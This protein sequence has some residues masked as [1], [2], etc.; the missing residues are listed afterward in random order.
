MQSSTTHKVKCLLVDAGN[1]ALAAERVIKS[2]VERASD[3]LQQA[4]DRDRIAAK[5][6]AL[7]IRHRW[8]ASDRRNLETLGIKANPKGRGVAL[9]KKYE[10]PTTKILNKAFAI[11]RLYA[12]ETL[13]GERLRILRQ[14]TPWFNV[15][16]EALYR[17]EHRI[18]C[19]LGESAPS[20]KAYGRAADCLMMTADLLR[21]ICQLVRNDRRALGAPAEPVLYV[22]DFEIWK[23]TG[24]FPKHQGDN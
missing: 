6:E 21:K 15:F 20:V 2:F 24:S 22:S 7:A 4:E 12:L 13:P 1:L 10:T 5:T 23:K 18:A 14:E 11:Q 9:V 17:G 16:A 19:E 3:E 8:K